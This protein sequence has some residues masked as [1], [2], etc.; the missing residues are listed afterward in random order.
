MRNRGQ[1]GR[2]LYRT[3][4]E[5]SLTS[6][7]S[8]CNP[9][10]GEGAYNTLSAFGHSLLQTSLDGQ[11]SGGQGGFSPLHPLTRVPLD[12]VAVERGI[13]RT[14]AVPVRTMFERRAVRWLGISSRSNLSQHQNPVLSHPEQD[15]GHERRQGV[16]PWSLDQEQ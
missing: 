15:L 16:P 10:V 8:L 14:G 12:P 7:R 1:H 6:H 3:S 9:R 4:V 5:D 11:A 13:E 2:P